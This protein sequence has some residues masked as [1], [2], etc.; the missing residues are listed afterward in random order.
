MIKKLFLFYYNNG[1]YLKVMSEFQ[2][3]EEFEQFVENIMKQ[4]KDDDVIGISG[5]EGD[6]AIKGCELRSIAVKDPFKKEF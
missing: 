3:N 5:N 6:Y 4:F 2:N 1:E